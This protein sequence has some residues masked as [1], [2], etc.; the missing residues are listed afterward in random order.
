MPFSRVD[1]LNY[2]NCSDTESMYDK[3]LL[4]AEIALIRQ[5]ISEGAKVLDA[6]CG[7]GEST[8]AYSMIPEVV[9]HAADFSQTRLQMAAERVGNRANVILKQVDFLGSYSL[10]RDYDVVVSQRFLINL[11]EW[12]LQQKVLLDM[13]GI[14][15]P[16]GRL[17]LLEGSQQGAY[18]LNALR[19]VWGLEPI[20]VKWHN[21]FLDDF[22]LNDFMQQ[23]GYRLLRMDGLGTYFLLT[24]GIRPTLDTDLNWDRDFNHIAASEK[25]KELLGFTT[26]YS[27]LRLWVFQK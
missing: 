17:L 1:S 13:M 23:N 6:G 25:M 4:G 18:E 9:I 20:P 26:R 2:W 24:R 11:T 12:E 14:L 7:E 16:G 5:H 27:R 19:A 10:D 21:L 15:K 8:L 22:S 3:Y